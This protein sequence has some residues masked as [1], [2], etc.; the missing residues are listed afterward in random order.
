MCK[1]R[2]DY[3]FSR[4]CVYMSLNQLLC[5]NPAAHVKLKLELEERIETLESNLDLDLDLDQRAGMKMGII[6][7]NVMGTSASTLYAIVV[8]PSY[9]VLC[10]IVFS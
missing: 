10:G 3:L 8:L 9:T 5:P 6:I 1:Q 2:L 7:C 4:D